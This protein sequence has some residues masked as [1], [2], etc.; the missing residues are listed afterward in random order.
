MVGRRVI[1]NINF[2]MMVNMP[3]RYLSVDMR[4]EI[5]D[6]GLMLNGGFRRD[7]RKFDVGEAITLKEHAQALSASQALSQSRKSTGPLPLQQT[8]LQAHLHAQRRLRLVQNLRSID[9]QAHHGKST[10]HDA[11]SRARQL[12][13]RRA[14]SRTPSRV[15]DGEL[16]IRVVGVVGG[17]FVCVEY[18]LRVSRKAVKVVSGKDKSEGL[19]AAQTSGARVGLRAKW[20]GGEL[21]SRGKAGGACAPGSPWYDTG[22]GAGTPSPYAGYPGTAQMQSPYLPSPSMFASQM[23]MPAF[24]PAPG[25]FS[26]NVN[27]GSGTPGMGGQGGILSVPPSPMV[28]GGINGNGGGYVAEGGH[29]APPRRSVVSPKKDDWLFIQ[30]Y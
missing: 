4:D 5:G 8:K 21:R 19:V 18:G 27:L 10:H 15:E 25:S 1:F 24:G 16:F 29:V 13:A 30:R 23:G 3:C 9:G 6:T 7:G 28:N 17:V 14:Q 12:R 2:D 11:G 26:P 20:A 22:L